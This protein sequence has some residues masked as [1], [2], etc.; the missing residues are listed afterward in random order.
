MN[1]MQDITDSLNTGFIDGSAVS[2]EEYQPRLLINDNK[3]GRK[4]LTC[5]IDELR[6][7]DEFF[8]SVAFITNGG[9]AALINTLIE[10]KDRGIKGKIV[11][12]Q[13]QNFTQPLALT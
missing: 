2:L 9:V 11:A 5:L 12:S 4:I 13:Y 3:R 6:A 8:F 10:L 7:C 1:L